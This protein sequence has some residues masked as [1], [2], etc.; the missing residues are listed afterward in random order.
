MWVNGR[1][2]II[3]AWVSAKEQFAAL[4]AERDMLKEENDTLK[5]QFDRL[6]HELKDVTDEFRQLRKAVLARQNAQDELAA[7]RR[8]RE[9]MLALR[10]ERDPALPL[11]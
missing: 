5:H 1:R 8:E 4:V 3:H 2:A 7:L 6:L 9:L 10:A 11:Q